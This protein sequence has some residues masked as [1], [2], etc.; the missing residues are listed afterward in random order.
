MCVLVSARGK[1]RIDALCKIFPECVFYLYS[2]DLDEE[3]DP[4]YAGITQRYSINITNKFIQECKRKFR[5]ILLICD[6][7]S[8]TRQTILHRHV[9]PYHSLLQM[10]VPFPEDVYLQGQLLW[11]LWCPSCLSGTL[12]L[13]CVGSCGYTKYNP[14]LLE[15]EL[16]AFQMLTRSLWDNK[17]DQQAQDYILDTFLRPEMRVES[18][19][20][21]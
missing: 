1:S 6:G 2:T 7:E 19:L 20:D 14:K 16:C 17:Y 13:D 4:M 3:Y 9:Q 5:R 10:S 18:L 21:C 8:H 12:Y 15:Q 11:P